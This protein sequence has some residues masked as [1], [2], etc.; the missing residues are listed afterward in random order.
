M[1]IGVLLWVLSS[2]EDMLQCEIITK[3]MAKNLAVSTYVNLF[4]ITD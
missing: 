4:I 2:Y 1:P 3:Y